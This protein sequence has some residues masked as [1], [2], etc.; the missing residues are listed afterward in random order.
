MHCCSKFW[1]FLFLKQRSELELEPKQPL[2]SRLRLQPKRAAPAP[3]HFIPVH[4]DSRDQCFGSVCIFD[5]FGSSLKSEYKSVSSLFLCLVGNF[6]WVGEGC[7]PF[8][9]QSIAC[10]VCAE[11]FFWMLRSQTWPLG[12]KLIFFGVFF[13]FCVHFYLSL[14]FFLTMR[15][16]SVQNTLLGRI[17]VDASTG[18]SQ[19]G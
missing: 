8:A 18:T 13:L 7:Y 16:H 12:W 2:F 15:Y 5:G 6:K 14:D 10:G 9:H 3:Q 11:I 19:E 4:M 17:P 1:L